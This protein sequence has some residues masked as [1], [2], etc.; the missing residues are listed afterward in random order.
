MMPAAPVEP[1]GRLSREISRCT[2]HRNEW[3]K[4]TS[5]MAIV[6]SF[7]LDSTASGANESVSFTE[8]GAPILLAEHAA[9]GASGNFSGQTLTVSG[10]LTEDQIGFA[11]GILIAGNSISIGGTT[12]GTFTGGIGAD[13]VVTFN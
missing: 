6:T 10:L 13:F 2:D 7:D 11:G 1:C 8:N 4:G 3:Q 12:I 9:V 5:D